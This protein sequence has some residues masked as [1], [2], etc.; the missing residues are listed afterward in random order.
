MVTRWPEAVAFGAFTAIVNSMVNDIVMPLVG[1]VLGGV[2]FASLSI[3][4]GDATI[5][6]GSFIQAVLTF[7]IIALVMFW[8]VRLMN[9]FWQAEEAAPAGP[10]ADVILLTEIRDLLEKQQ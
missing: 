4:V 8:V 10:A 5:A 6:Y 1:V 7:V 9:R 3:D 2:D